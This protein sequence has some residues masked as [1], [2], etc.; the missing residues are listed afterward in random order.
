[1]LQL[2]FPAL[3]MGDLPYDSN[4]QVY[5]T[6]PGSTPACIGGLVKL[7]Q[8]LFFTEPQKKPLLLAITFACNIPM[9]NWEPTADRGPRSPIRPRA[10]GGGRQTKPR[11][12]REKTP[13]PTPEAKPAAPRGSP[14]ANKLGRHASH[15]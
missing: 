13:Q 9:V 10:R 1:M 11:A 3:H 5:Y 7:T 12:G 6:N 14:I 8:R 2:V 15:E 4:V